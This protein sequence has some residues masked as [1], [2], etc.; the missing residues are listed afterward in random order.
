LGSIALKSLTDVVKHSNRAGYEG[1]KG[2]KTEKT[3]TQGNPRRRDRRKGMEEAFKKEE[4][5]TWRL[6]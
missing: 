6:S 2:I 1:K 4:L 5:V 3:Q